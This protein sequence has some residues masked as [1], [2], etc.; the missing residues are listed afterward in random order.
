MDI[1]TF[2]AK[3]GIASVASRIDASERQRM[4]LQDEGSLILAKGNRNLTDELTSQC[5]YFDSN[6]RDSFCG[7]YVH[8]PSVLILSS[9]AR[10]LTQIPVSGPVVFKKRKEQRHLFLPFSSENQKLFQQLSALVSFHLITKAGNSSYEKAQLNDYQ[11]SVDSVIENCS[12]RKMIKKCIRIVNQQYVQ[13]QMI[14]CW[15][16]NDEFNCTKIQKK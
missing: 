6:S 5:L 12:L 2:R 4:D 11:E 1:H 7:L 3:K 15:V 10:W 9:V 8:I 16:Q 13:Q 14:I